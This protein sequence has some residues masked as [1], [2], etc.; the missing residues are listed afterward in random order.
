MSS[1][2][3]SARVALQRAPNPPV[4]SVAVPPVER[5]LPSSPILSLKKCDRGLGFLQTAP[6]TQV[7][8]RRSSVGGSTAYFGV[9]RRRTSY[10]HS[11][12]RRVE[13]RKKTYT[14]RRTGE[15]RVHVCSSCHTCLSFM[16]MRPSRE[17]RREAATRT[18]VEGK[19]SRGRKAVHVH[20][21][22]TR[23]M[24]QTVIRQR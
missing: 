22:R 13:R 5:T 19:K 10:G 18:P 4:G 16:F 11:S 2:G 17:K 14:A 15:E 24:H 21:S 20:V 1:A 6:A 7:R 23:N 3:A 8:K 9:N 12:T